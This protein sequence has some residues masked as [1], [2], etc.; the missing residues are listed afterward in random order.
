MCGVRDVADNL[1]NWHPLSGIVDKPIIDPY[2][3]GDLTAS[4]DVRQGE[5]I[6]QKNKDLGVQDMQLGVGF[7]AKSIAAGAS[8]SA[9]SGGADA[10]A[11]GAGADFEGV[12]TSASSQGSSIGGGVGSDTLGGDPATDTLEPVDPNADPNTNVNTGPANA[13]FIDATTP[14]GTLTPE[15]AQLLGVNGTGGFD[16]TNVGGFTDGVSLSPGGYSESIPTVPDTGPMDIPGGGAGGG[17]GYLD[18]ASQLLK[19]LGLSPV[20]AGLLGVSGLQ[21]L[22]KPK[23]P[24]A[25]NTLRGSAT[26]GSQQANSVIQS[27]GQASP[28]WTSQ[29]ASIDASIDQQLQQQT[30]AIMQQAQNSGQGGKSQ[31][32]VQQINALK[33]KLETQRQQ[34]YAQAQGQNVQ[35]ALQ[36]LGIS[37]QALSG[38][39]AAQYKASQDARSSAGQTAALALQLQALS[40]R[41]GG[42]AGIVP[43]GG[44]PTG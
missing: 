42:N 37:D 38:V 6:D 19:K 1:N 8:G 36:Q 40:N 26:Q 10:G 2:L 11:A 22:T 16:S 7:L 39:A 44:Q 34:L 23:T 32:T 24:D 14:T 20:S 33:T 18:Q 25:A 29:K 27:G 28:A 35:A 31:V 41:G 17:G 12:G 15:T 21:A 13:G 4:G 9:M 3:Q 30:Q 5:Y 43:N